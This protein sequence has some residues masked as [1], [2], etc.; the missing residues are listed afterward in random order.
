MSMDDVTTI[1]EDKTRKSVTIGLNPSGTFQSIDRESSMLDADHMDE[2]VT[3]ANE[4]RQ[5]AA[6]L[7]ETGKLPISIDNKCL[8]SMQD[9]R[10][11]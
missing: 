11:T 8:L 6:A 10:D 9:G 3:I 1:I 5:A 2:K 4:Y 7:K